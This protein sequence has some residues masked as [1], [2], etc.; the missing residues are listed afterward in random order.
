M[1]HV[2]HEYL[3]EEVET[4]ETVQMEVVDE[5]AS[6]ADVQVMSIL[7]EAVDIKEKSNESRENEMVHSEN[8]IDKKSIKVLVSDNYLLKRYK[9]Y[10]HL[11]IKKYSM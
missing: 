1:A 2:H 9:N 6:T 11:T 5:L 10:I 3:E 7:P 4:Q 8:K